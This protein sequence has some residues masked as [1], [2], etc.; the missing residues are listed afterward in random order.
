[1]KKKSNNLD[2]YLFFAKRE[3]ILHKSLCLFGL[4][5]YDEDKILS[6]LT[7]EIEHRDVKVLVC[8]YCG[9]RLKVDR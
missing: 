5:D 6:Y 9:K 1:M 4:H 7:S 3:I 8:F 2:E